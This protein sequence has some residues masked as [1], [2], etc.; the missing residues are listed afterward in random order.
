MSNEKVDDKEKKAQ[1][2]LAEHRKAVQAVDKINKLQ[3]YRNRSKNKKKFDIMM[4][5]IKGLIEEQQKGKFIL[6][7]KLDMDLL[8]D[9]IR[10]EI[11][12]FIGVAYEDDMIGDSN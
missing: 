10:A 12:R 8:E 9:N 5:N 3:K 7:K 11:N 4:S 2:E 6:P 1:E